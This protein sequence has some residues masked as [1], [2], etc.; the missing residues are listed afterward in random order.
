MESQLV[1]IFQF[2]VL[3]FETFS[4]EM[5]SHPMSSIRAKSG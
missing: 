5:S 4:Q 2:G 3:Y 1:T